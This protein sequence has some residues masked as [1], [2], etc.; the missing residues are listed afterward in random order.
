M[1]CLLELNS[2]DVDAFFALKQF[3]L[4]PKPITDEEIGNLVTGFG[5]DGSDTEEIRFTT[6]EAVRRN[7]E[8]RKL[9]KDKKPV[10]KPPKPKEPE[11]QP[12]EVEEREEEEEQ[13]EE[14][15]VSEDSEVEEYQEDSD[16]DPEKGGE[17]GKMWA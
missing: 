3:L 14:E 8:Q 5:D 6:K 12:E 1:A 17:K 7:S 16:D 13:E 9:H 4:E 10:K 15:E 2:D 11:E